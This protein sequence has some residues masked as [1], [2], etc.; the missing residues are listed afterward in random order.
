MVVRYDTLAHR[1]RQEGHLRLLDEA[2]YLL[3]S[4]CPGGAFADN[5]E[6]VTPRAQCRQG[7]F[8]HCRVDLG[9]SGGFD[10]WRVLEFLLVNP[11]HNN[12]ARQVQVDWPRPP[13]NGV[14]HGRSNIAWN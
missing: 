7:F 14:A 10:T 2:P 9:R 1:R 3:L 12:I 8:D 13:G 5:G 4:P 6:G 11:A